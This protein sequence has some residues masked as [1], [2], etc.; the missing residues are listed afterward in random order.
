MEI[1]NES[2]ETKE[3][4][5]ENAGQGNS[6]PSNKTSKWTLEK[7]SLVVLFVIFAVVLAGAWTFALK[8]Q[9]TVAGN[10]TVTHADP[11]A[12]I[13]V[14]RLRNLASSQLDNSRAFFL[15]GSQ[16]LYDK[17]GRAHV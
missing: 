6:K 2:I 15:L 8:L 16:S 5:S 7:R 14:E 11:S 3:A 13:E 17:I 4:V 10:R 9:Q 12:M 1:Q